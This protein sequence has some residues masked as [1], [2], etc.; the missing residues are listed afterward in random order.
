[1]TK[2]KEQQT[3]VHFLLYQSFAQNKLM[4]SAFAAIHPKLNR[5]LSTSSFAAPIFQRLTAYSAHFDLY[6]SCYGILSAHNDLVNLA[7]FCEWV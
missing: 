7:I 4:P 6:F 2:A 5:G 3:V 1:V